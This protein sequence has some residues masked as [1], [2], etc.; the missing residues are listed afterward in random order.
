VQH[1]SAKF[2]RRLDQRGFTLIELV[3]IIVVLGILAAVAVPK[4][5]DM[6]DS[7][8]TA[9]TRK[10]LQSLRESIVGNPE[11]VS[12]GVVIDRGFL[13]D[14]G[15]VPSQLSDLVVKPD[16][17]SAYDKL[18]RLGWNGPYIDG[19]GNDYQSDAWGVAYSYDPAGQRIV[20]VGG[21]DSIQITF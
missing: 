8:K 4:F 3:I 12:S 5:A 1:R 10:E 20:S 11:V 7:S 6:M 19:D 13:G 21:P 9:A 16:S 18:T 15:F 2:C 14:V 17:V